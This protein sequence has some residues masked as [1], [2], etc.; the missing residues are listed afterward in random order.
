MII[1]K[2]LRLLQPV[3]AFFAVLSVSYVAKKFYGNIA[4]T[5]AGFLI[6]SSYLFSRLVSPLPETMAIIFVPLVVYLYYK[7]VIS[8]KYVYALISSILFL[9]V[10]LTHQATTLLLFLIIT[11]ITLVVGIIKRNRSFIPSYAIFLSIPIIA[12]L[13]LYIAALLMAPNYANSILTVITT[14]TP[15]LPHSEPI[16]IFKYMVYLGIVLIFVI[17]GSVVALKRRETKDLFIIVW[18][19]VIFFMSNSYWFG[20]NVYTMRL[21]IH[22]LIPL[23]IL[24]GLGLSYLY[25]D[26]KKLEYPSKKVRT[27]FL[28]T[29]F[30]IT[31]LFAVSTVKDSNFEV[32][33]NHNSQP[34]GT[35][36]MIIPQIA[37]PTSS[38]MELAT[39]FDINGDK[40]SVIVSNNYA[41]NQFIVALTGQPVADVVS[42]EHVLEWG[43]GASELTDKN[44]G[45]FI[46]DKRLKFFLYPNKKI[47]SK[48][49]FIFYNSNFNI[50]TLIPPNAKLLYENSY[51]MVFKI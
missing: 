29:I 16:S 12:T 46:F 40:K 5:S 38:D 25:L 13:L 14:Y 50:T 41:T 32:I 35:S 11:S 10:I 51:Y 19:I 37:P 48:G 33:P 47:I 42:S 43:F 28:I 6:L 45:Y 2:L 3:L 20:V 22:L 34:Y 15:S 24:G 17:I 39:W 36:D 23:S 1:S 49:G 18:I 44:V 8:K 7:S 9:M 21:L 27:I 26:Y 31:T 30:L 4:G